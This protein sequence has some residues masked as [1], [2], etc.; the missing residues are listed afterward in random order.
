MIRKT[1]D[2]G[3]TSTGQASGTSAALNGV[4]LAPDGVHGWAVGA[5]GVIRRSTE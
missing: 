5:G 1:I 2:G 4:Q 3:A